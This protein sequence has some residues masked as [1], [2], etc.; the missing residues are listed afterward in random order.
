[1]AFCDSVRG[2]SEPLLDPSM[3]FGMSLLSL[4]PGKVGGAETYVRE[5]V[6]CLPAVAG[7]DEF[8]LILPRE[9]SR[10]LEAPG[11]RKVVV[12][13][14][15]SELVAAR[16]AEAFSPWRARA[17]ERLV[18]GLRAAAILFPQQSIFP[19][20]AAAPGVVTVGDV[21]H[22]VMPENFGLFDRAFRAA[23]YP[24]SLRR[25]RRIIAIS[26]F[27]KQMLVERA[28]VAA[29]KIQVVPHGFAPGAA[30]RPL[31]DLPGPYLYYP[32]ATFPHKNH[33][34]LFR[35]YA[36][37]RKRG[38]IEE[39]LLLTGARTGLWPRLESLIRELGMT[40]HVRHL[41]HLPSE[42]V[43]RVYAG[44]SAI[45][46]ATLFEGLGLPVLEA[47][48]FGKR[49]VVSRLQVFDEIG[50]PARFQIDFSDPDQLLGA[51][52]APGPFALEK[53][54]LTWEETAR[55]TLRELRRAA[56]TA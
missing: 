43:P 36:A 20:R 22:L 31:D 13:R 30:A 38:A 23:I 12:D 39:P 34:A 10:D 32:A 50:V 1:M 19:K 27:T 33:A 51:L 52:R 47:A 49:I 35:S 21:Q 14:S 48:S 18:D 3:N 45:L 7:G 16:V 26:R 37:L 44:A 41:G 25:A 53:R 29:E 56:E 6:R 9:V 55:A 15:D 54:P 42:E 2:Q 5:L 28:G 4:R 11:W 24:Y 17:I 8:S 46:F 40:P